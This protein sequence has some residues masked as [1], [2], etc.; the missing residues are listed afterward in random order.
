MTRPN[1]AAF[2][3]A[4][5]ALGIA[6]ILLALTPFNAFA[7]VRARAPAAERAATH[8][9]RPAT[10]ATPV[11]VRGAPNL[12]RVAPNLYRSAQP[13]SSGFKALAKDPGIKTV[14]SLRAFNSDKL[15]IAGT[16]INLTRIPI[17]TWHI[18]TEDVVLALATIR[19]AETMGP[20]LLHCQHGAD[21]TGLITALYRVLYQGWTKEAAREEMQDGNFGYHAVWGNIPRYLRKVDIEALRKL[22]ETAAL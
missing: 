4:A 5:S 13:K 2:A 22:V 20:V 12:F 14:V 3:A 10:W 1:K 11:T 8:E 18:E 19:K 9:T 17:H 15:L 7:K 6:T 21:R 16:G